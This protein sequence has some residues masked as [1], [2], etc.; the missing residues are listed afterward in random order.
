MHRGVL[1]VGAQKIPADTD[2]VILCTFFVC[3]ETVLCVRT[4]TASFPKWTSL[5]FLRQDS[6]KW[7]RSHLQQL[8]FPTQTSVTVAHGVTRRVWCPQVVPLHVKTASM[9]CGRIVRKDDT[10]FQDMVAEMT[11][12]YGDKK[13]VAKEFLEGC[14]YAVQVD[15]EI[16]RWGAAPAVATMTRTIFCLWGTTR[17]ISGCKWVH[18][19]L[20]MEKGFFN[21]LLIEVDGTVYP[22]AGWRSCL[23]LREAN[24]SSSASLS[25][26]LTWDMRRRSN[27]TRSCCFRSSSTL[28]L[29]RRWRS[30]SA[31]SNRP[32]TSLNGTQR[33]PAQTHNHVSSFWSS[34][35]RH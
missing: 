5:S 23:S 34:V 31:G 9:F 30:S 32:T 10:A 14:V 24:S 20:L 25:A 4:V 6:S 22:A 1:S 13:P 7:G 17:N 11:V 27:R 33:S 35:T 16:H 18:V 29:A 2:K 26:S 19:F 3:A 28:C 12:Y 21:S 8:H 15:E